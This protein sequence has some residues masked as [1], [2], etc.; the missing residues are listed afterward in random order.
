MCFL[1]V[2]SPSHSSLS[3]LSITFMWVSPL[4]FPQYLFFWVLYRSMAFIHKQPCRTSWVLSLVDCPLHNELHSVPCYYDALYFPECHPLV[5]EDEHTVCEWL[6][7]EL[8]N[9][10]M[11][12]ACI[13]FS[14]VPSQSHVFVHYSLG[15][16]VIGFGGTK[17]ILSVDRRCWIANVFFL[18]SL[19]ASVSK[20]WSCRCLDIVHSIC[21]VSAPWLFHNDCDYS[22]PLNKL[23]HSDLLCA[24]HTV[25]AVGRLRKANLIQLL[26]H[27]F[28][29]SWTALLDL[30]KIQI[31]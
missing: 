26:V 19:S 24:A 20:F 7:A 18:Q 6:H 21:L 28:V 2:S 5:F 14:R 4:Y 23:S 1:S 25:G 17:I 8:Q 22:W 11:I 12:C 16:F 15:N 29:I 31:K 30:I 3:L 9:H 10:L 27:D 13:S